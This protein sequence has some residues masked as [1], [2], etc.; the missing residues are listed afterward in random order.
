MDTPAY[1][2]YAL[3]V[4][5]ESVRIALLIADLNNFDVL[6]GNVHNAYLNAPPCEKYWFKAVP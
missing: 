3:M 4:S 6:S 5:W 2:T 1:M